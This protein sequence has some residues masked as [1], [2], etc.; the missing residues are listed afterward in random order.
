MNLVTPCYVI[1]L[2][3][4]EKNLEQV[5][6]LREKALCKIFFSLKG[7]STEYLLPKL[8]N[9]LDGISASGSFEAHLGK[10]LN[11]T[12]STFSPAYS[13]ESFSVITHDSDMIVFNSVQQYKDFSSIA[14]ESGIS[15][16]IRINPEYTELPANFSA[17][18]CQRYSRL[19]VLK[20]DL[21]P[22]D[23]FGPGKIEGVHLHTMCGQNADT[24]SRT[25]TFLAENF[26]SIL[27]RVS[28]INLGGG[29]LYGADDYHMDLAI[30]CI[31]QLAT[32]YN[33][34][35][36]TE[37]CEGVLIGCGFFV[38]TVLDIVH[39]EMDIAI[40][41]GSA[42]CHLSDAVYRGWKRDVLG[43]A[44]SG[45]Y[46]YTV[47]LA[48]NSCYAGDIFGDYSFPEPIKRGDRIIFCDTATYTTVKACMFNG[49]PFPSVGVYSRKDGFQTKKE[50]GYDIFR[51]TL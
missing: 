39:N 15:C 18:P 22:L 48:G 36:L 10:S 33:V 20:N 41:D 28:W 23:N 38:T 26:D 46:P 45:F 35:I 44:D 42:I 34:P 27:K 2:D 3:R 43:G 32:Y 13:A 9:H 7:F 12:V 14:H 51:K 19:G 24:L 47:R 50:Y 29:Q 25:I 17:N 16:G 4:L 8:L 5:S 6:S 37:P 11:A 30:K 40:L 21:P 31:N 49:I 1:D